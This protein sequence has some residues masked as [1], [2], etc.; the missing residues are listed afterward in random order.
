MRHTLP[1]RQLGLVRNCEDSSNFGRDS[2]KDDDGI[3]HSVLT[4]FPLC[5]S[6]CYVLMLISFSN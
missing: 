5:T 4:K 3:Q 6:N 1:S 2:I